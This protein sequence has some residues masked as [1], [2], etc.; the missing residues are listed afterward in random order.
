VTGAGAEG[1]GGG[2]QGADGGDVQLRHD[3]RHQRRRKP[4]EARLAG[5]A[6]FFLRS[7]RTRTRTFLGSSLKHTFINEK[8]KIIL[9]P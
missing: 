8:I 9:R 6:S 7:H 4:V 3:G 5:A 1:G 2:G